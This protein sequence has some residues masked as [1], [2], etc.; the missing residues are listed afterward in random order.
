MKSRDRKSVGTFV[1]FAAV[2]VTSGTFATAGFFAVASASPSHPAV[3]H[4]LT[5]TP[6]RL[7]NGRGEYGSGTRKAAV[8][9][10]S[11][12][13]VHFKGAIAT[14]GSNN[15]AFTLPK[16]FWPGG[17]VYVRVDMCNA[18]NGRLEIDRDGVVYVDAETSFTNAQCF[19]SLEG[20][21]YTP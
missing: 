21:S 1:M 11:D 15:V 3:R 18:T 17:T 7:Q 12:G 19:T 13:I 16:A 14:G 5:Y 8:A 20:V 2:V 6:L 10:D 9:K 4:G